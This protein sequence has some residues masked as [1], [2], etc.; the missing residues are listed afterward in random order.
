MGISASFPGAAIGLA[1]SSLPFKVPF[2]LRL[3]LVVG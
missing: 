3:I 2:V 1:F